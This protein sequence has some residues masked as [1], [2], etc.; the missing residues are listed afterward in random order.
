MS[1]TGVGERFRL[2]TQFKISRDIVVIKNL[3]VGSFAAV[4][5]ASDECPTSTPYESKVSSALYGSNAYL[6]RLHSR[7]TLPE[8]C[9][10]DEP[11]HRILALSFSTCGRTQT[12]ERAVPKYRPVHIRQVLCLLTRATLYACSSTDASKSSEM[13]AVISADRFI[14]STI[15]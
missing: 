1:G 9:K 2:M 8:S 6:P 14:A 12:S 4:T 10:T 7:E 13:V 15:S 3:V 11:L 5:P